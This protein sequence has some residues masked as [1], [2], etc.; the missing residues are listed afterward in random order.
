MA[1]SVENQDE[2]LMAI[3][4]RQEE[5]M[6]E[7]MDMEMEDQ[8][9]NSDETSSDEEAKG[10]PTK[11]QRPRTPIS[12]EA[13]TRNTKTEDDM[14]AKFWTN[15]DYTLDSEI[16]FGGFRWNSLIEIFEEAII[17]PIPG[18]DV[19]EEF[20]DTWPEGMESE[21]LSMEDREKIKAKKDMEYVMSKMST[22]EDDMYH[23]KK[24]LARFEGREGTV[25]LALESMAKKIS[26]LTRMLTPDKLE[27]RD[28][29]MKDEIIKNKI[30]EIAH[31]IE[32]N[33]L[34]TLVKKKTVRV[35]ELEKQLGTIQEAN[36]NNNNIWREN[37]ERLE[38]EL[39]STRSEFYNLSFTSRKDKYKGKNPLLED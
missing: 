16:D 21:F 7:L 9:Y 28:Q 23:L 5:I 33:T 17:N 26:N 37:Y 31:E 22:M 30:K 32:I 4:W 19:E 20:L 27:E 11:I 35:K 24:R 10:E 6:K 29:T 15:M 2:I 36:W 25:F 14:E 38:E 13:T 1:G 18:P 12:A 3:T 34:K 8:L 39:E